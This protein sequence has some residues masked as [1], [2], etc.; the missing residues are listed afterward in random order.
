MELEPAQL[1]QPEDARPSGE[2]VA[3]STLR[4]TGTRRNDVRAPS[5]GIPVDR[6]VPGWHGLDLCRA[7]AIL[8]GPQPGPTSK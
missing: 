2:R 4:A 3:A 6:A 5:S 8:T 7:R 1:W